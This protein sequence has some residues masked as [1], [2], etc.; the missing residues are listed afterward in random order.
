MHIR[1]LKRRFVWWLSL[2]LLSLALAGL[3]AFGVQGLLVAL[4]RPVLMLFWFIDV[5]PE[6]VVWAVVVILGAVVALR[7][8]GALP[9]PHHHTRLE[10]KKAPVSFAEN[11]TVASIASLVKRVETSGVARDVLGRH[12]AELAVSLLCR[13][14]CI[15]PPEAWRLMHREQW[16]TD[17]R[18]YGVLF[19]EQTSHPAGEHLQDLEYAVRFLEH[20]DRGGIDDNSRG[21]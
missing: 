2:V 9:H 17:Q 21:S 10:T 12:L 4:I 5:L 13:R 6:I 15:S 11:E 16:P 18:V 14:R 3:F 19:P 20:Y 1:K 7:A 8:R